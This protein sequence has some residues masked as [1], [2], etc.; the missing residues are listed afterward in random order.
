MLAVSGL[1]AYSAF[2]ALQSADPQSSSSSISATQSNKES[3]SIQVRYPVTKTSPESYDEIGQLAPMDLKN[4]SNL[5]TEVEYDAETNCYVIHTRVAGVDVCTPFMLS[6][7]EYNDYT[8]RKSMQ[9]YYRERNAQN[10]AE[11]SKSEFNFLDMQFSL[12]PL[13]KVFGPG[14]VQLKTQGSIELNMGLK[15]NKLDN[16]ALPMSSR[17]KTYFDFDEKIQASVTAKVGD[18]MS[19]NMNYNTD[20][21][22][23]FDSKNLKLQYQGK[24][25]EIIK[26]IEAGNVSMTTGSS[27]IRGSTALFGVKTTM[28]FGKLTAT[29]LISQQQSESKTVNASGG[30]QTTPFEIRADAY[31]EN[32]HFFLAHFFRDNYDKFAS[33]LPYVS[34]GV[35]INRIEVWITNKQG[36]YEESRNIVG[37]MDLAENV[38]I[39]NDHW[40]SATAQQNPMNNSNSLYA[41]IKNGYPDARNINLVTQAL[42]PLSVY[43]IE[44]GQDYVKIESARKLA[45]SEYTLNSQLGYI[46]LKSKLNAD[47]MIAVAYEYTYNGQVYQVGEF[48]G[49]V[50]DTDQCLFLKMLK[51]STIST[52]LPIWDL[53]MKNVYSLGAYQVQKDKF[54]LYIKYQNDSTGVAVNNIP[55][56]NI[57]NQTLLQVMNLDRLDANESEYS[58]GIFDYIEGY[59]IQSSNGRIIFPVIEPFGSHLAEKIGN[60]AIAEKYVYQ[61]LYDSTLTIAQ[62]VSEKN[63]FIMTGEYK[64]SSGAEIRLNAMNVPRG[65]VVVTAGG[66]TLVEN[67]DYI[68]DY[69]MGVVTILNQSIIEA[70]TPISIS[71][72]NQSMFNMQRK[73]MLGLDLNYAFSKD[74]NVGATIMHLSEKSLTEKVNMGDEVLNNTLW[75]VNLS[76]NTNFLWLTN[77]LN[78]IPT[79]NATAPSTLALTAEF[80]QLIPHKSKNG[81]SQGTSYIDDFE[82]TQT[83]LDLKSPY[84]WTLAST[85]YDPSSDALFPEARYSNDIRYGQNRALL[86]WYYID[87]MFTQKNST[88]IPAHLKNDLD[89]L[90]NPYVREVSVREIF[91]NKEINYGE[92][93]TLQ[94]LNLSFYP[95]ERGPYN[96]DADNI[97]SQG[98]LLNPENRWGGIMRKMDYTDFESSNIEYIQFWLMD[99]FL[100][101]NQTN[102]N[103]GEL[104]FNLG[105]VSE[106]ILKDG[107]KSFENGLPVD[108]DTTQI[109]TT[110]WGKVSKRQSLTYAFDNTSGARALQ[111]VGLDGLSNDEEYGFPSY[112]DYLNKLETKL[113]PAVVEAMRQDQFSPFNDPAGDNYHFYRGHDYDDA[114][115]SILDRYKRYN[116]T[117]NNSRS[118]EEMNDSY[119]QS[120]K[121]VP[122]VE[123]INQDNTLNEYERYYQYRI[124]L[125]PDSLEVGKNCITDKR[126]TTVRLRNGEEGKAVWYQF[127][128]PLSRPQKK[129]G[130]IQDFKTIRF[131][132]MFMTGFECETHLRFATLELVRGEWRTYNYALNLKGDA[133]AQ[134]KMDISVVN[135]EENAGQ[136]P[137]NYVL[138]PGV[139]RIIDP[140]QSQITQL[141][142]QAMSLKVTDLQSGDA[143]AVYKNS[144]MDMR[145]YKRLQMFVHAEKLID[146]KTN[147]RDGDVSVFLRLGSDSKSNY[148]EYEVPLSLTE[149]G[150]YSTYNAQDQEAVWPQ[151]NMFD[152]PL[153]LF[154]DLK[155]ERNAKKRMDNSTVTFQTRYSS[156][157]PDKNQNKVTIVGNP[158]LSDV[159]TMMIGV[160]NNSNAAKDIVVWVNEMRLTDFDQ[161][162]GWAAKANVNLGLSD[163]ATLNIAGHVETVGFG[164]IDQS[165][166]ERRL[167]D[168]YQYNIATMVELGRFLPEKVKLKAPLFYS[169]TEQRTSPKYNPLDQDILLKDALDN[170]GSKAERDSISDASIEKSTVESFSLSGVSFD[171]RSKNPMPYD[172]ANFSISYS[173]N[174]QSK[175]DPTTEFENTYDYR[176]SFTYSY[177]PFV[178][179]FVPLK[180]LKSK[181]KH[182]KFLKEWEFNYL[183]NNIAFNTNMSRYYYEQQIRDVSGSGGMALPTSVSKSFLWDRQFSLTW[184]LTKSINLSLQTMTNAHIEEPVGVVNKQL[185]P[186]EYEA[187]KDTVLTSIKNLGTPWNYNQTFNASYTAPF[188]KIPVLDYLSFNAKYNATYTWDRGAQI[189][190]E[191]DLGNSVNNQGQLSFDGRFNFEQLYNKSK[192][193]QKI[194]KRFSS[195]NRAAA[196]KKNRKFERT[197]CFGKILRL[198]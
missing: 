145:T 20:A 70:G 18:K 149:P 197:I 125:C 105:E 3:D 64:A 172:P 40:I 171:I 93:T 17:K 65:S 132:R 124:S 143:R 112:R 140:G 28:Q 138:P 129:V 109:A 103:G 10:F 8:L 147:L 55:E 114:Q 170:A 16:P 180:G 45:S 38:H 89:Q 30:A 54:R 137:V 51:G 63:K 118:P 115:T 102:H 131:I 23:D 182:L 144:G 87:R 113:S 78:K 91:P 59:T 76:Y 39:G 110:V 73:T 53:M 49:D 146:D 106:D 97:D 196:A 192:Y 4:P 83:G 74:F 161:S 90:S 80:A 31:D 116:G 69:A 58:D 84:S 25:D 191:I 139:T 86:S 11:N 117:E 107:M 175:Q 198:L 164:G 43:G 178:K 133:P 162:G 176:G 13:E 35:S 165:L 123:D 22:F 152:F 150:N 14:G 67:S 77:L 127:K 48:S 36:N 6:A 168:Y 71:L 153:S 92:S 167:D 160:R 108:G 126:E 62:Q 154:T 186:D 155:L 24:E 148:Y 194:N 57:S 26:N 141:N 1:G 81:S 119:Y 75:G 7:A 95:Q 151:S 60:A 82:S 27:L 159:R 188:S 130:S 29:A 32:R 50:T 158:S 166:T 136:V 42:E 157:D 96:L 169:I 12:G 195:N 163:I 2:A 193:L 56:G 187:W 128:I 142:E 98:L 134:G 79:V 9:Q 190:E 15:H 181:S 41:E 183:P 104:Y 72:E 66:M 5:K 52:S 111:D 100:D 101:E 156:Y 21:T 47:E 68:V 177:T 37:F 34:S 19:F 121:S 122:D 185:F 33:K 85:P 120:S 99:P 61:E 179:P 46:S 189:S 88:L 94:T 184:N 173:Y 44:G 174:R 135:I